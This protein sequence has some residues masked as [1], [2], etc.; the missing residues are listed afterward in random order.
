[1]SETCPTCSCDGVPVIRVCRKCGRSGCDAC[2]P[3]Q[4]EELCPECE[5]IGNWNDSKDE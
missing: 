5:W 1:M 3:E 4:R 2:F